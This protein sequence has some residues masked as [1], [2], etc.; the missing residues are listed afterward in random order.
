MFEANGEEQER[1]HADNR[2][3]IGE[4]TGP[5]TASEIF[6]YLDCVLLELGTLEAVAASASSL[7]ECVHYAGKDIQASRLVHL[8]AHTSK[9]ASHLRARVADAVESMDTRGSASCECAAHSEQSEI[10][11]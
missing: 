4:A 10:D 2:L 8:V 6:H 3:E 9:L 7:L 11:E 1:A 5:V